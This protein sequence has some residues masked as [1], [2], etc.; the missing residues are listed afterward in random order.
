VARRK[1]K[2]SKTKRISFKLGTSKGKK[3]RKAG[4][5]RPSFTGVLKVFAAVSVL[6]VIGIGVFIAARAGFTFLDKYVTKVA[7][8][9][10]EFGS[11]ELVDFPDWINEQL[12][13]KI[14]AAA[15]ANGEDLKL[16]EDAARSVQSNLEREV[17]W[18]QNVTVQTTHDT[19]RIKAKWRKPI[20]R[21]ERGLRK[22][23]VDAELVVLDFVPMP[24]LPIVKVKG[25]S[26]ITKVPP[27]GTVCQQDDLAAAVAIL[28]GL[29]E[30]DKLVTPDKPLLY[31]IDRIDVSNFQGLE[32]TRFPHIVLYA[33]DNT[34]IIWGA[35]MRTWQRYLEATD[36]E[37]LL[38]LYGYYKEK[39]SLLGVKY[40]NL[41]DPQDKIPLPIDKF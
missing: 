28:T 22:F 7:P 41:R 6:G 21:V 35:E 27:P 38:K 39:G 3:Q 17:A 14:Y 13:D 24:N 30:M 8:A 1:R 2:K 15:T 20:A 23:Y 36:E 32:D 25:L 16:D 29:D 19:I 34:E 26:L 18:L 4:R 12:K 31:E 9:P 40:I 37:K 11:L 10:E 5:K 33:T